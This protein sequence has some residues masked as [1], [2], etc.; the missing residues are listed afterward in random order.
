MKKKNPPRGGVTDVLGATPIYYSTLLSRTKLTR[1]ESLSPPTLDNA[2]N[3]HVVRN[4]RLSVSTITV[5]KADDRGESYTHQSIK[6]RGRTKL[7]WGELWPYLRDQRTETKRWYTYRV[8]IREWGKLIKRRRETR[9]MATKEDWSPRWPNNNIRRKELQKK[10]MKHER[11]H[12]GL[13]WRV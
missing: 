4:V 12:C 1:L 3:V 7:T 10:Y 8:G 5:D 6:H 11:L 2:T 13:W 9:T